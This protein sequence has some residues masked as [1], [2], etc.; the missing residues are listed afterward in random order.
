MYTDGTGV[1]YC[2]RGIVVPQST[3]PVRPSPCRRSVQPLGVTREAAA[4]DKDRNGA[5]P[6]DGQPKGV[7]GHGGAPIAGWFIYPSFY[8]KN[9]NMMIHYFMNVHEWMV[10]SGKSSNG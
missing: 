9:P 4:E 7:H 2:L 6:W 10:Y 5:W 1:S 3:I 8:D